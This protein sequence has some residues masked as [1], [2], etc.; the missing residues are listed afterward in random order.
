[1]PR[2]RDIEFHLASEQRQFYD[3]MNR[4]RQQPVLPVVFSADSCPLLE[5]IT[6]QLVWDHR[7]G[8]SD[9]RPLAKLLDDQLKKVVDQSPGERTPLRR[10]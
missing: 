4:Y 3:L 8:L 6:I 1:M 10:Y 5:T 2:L 9:L 7:M